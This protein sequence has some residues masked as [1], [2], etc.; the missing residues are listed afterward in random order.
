[1]KAGSEQYDDKH[2]VST[3]P[4]DENIELINSHRAESSY[5]LARKKDLS[6]LIPGILIFNIV[7]CILVN[8][9]CQKIMFG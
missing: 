3:D 8:I 2:R 5:F 1:M 4:Q 6:I 7:M 9:T